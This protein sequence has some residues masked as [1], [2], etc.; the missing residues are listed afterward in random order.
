MSSQDALS[1][2]VVIPAHNEEEFLA[3]ALESVARQTVLPKKV[4]I[5]N[6]HSTD[7]TAKIIDEYSSKYP[8]FKGVN[9]HSSDEHLP[10]S[11]VV[12]AFNKGLSLLNKDYDFLVK[13]DADV[14]LPANYF[15]TVSEVFR[16]S[17]DIGIAGG[18]A[19]E[20]NP[21]GKWILKHPM[22][23][24][25]IRGAFKAYSNS[26]FQAMNGLRTAMGWDTVDELL[27]QYHGFRTAA[28]NSLKVKHQRPIGAAYNI[29][30][31]R[32]QGKAMFLM[33]YGIIITMIASLKMAL[34]NGK[35]RIIRDNLHGYRDARKNA[36]PYIV[37]PEEGKFIRKL[38]WKRILRKLI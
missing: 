28:V 16:S 27:A 34:K 6:D 22:D 24:D 25:H 35:L 18:Y 32:S 23:K 4:V 1:Y 17:P 19:Y 12:A 21:E 11:K 8:F 30:A 10:G 3:D 15:E 5:V 20:K 29:K 9:N 36:V 26:C 31:R 38:R 14:V 7:G 13:L 33:R 37:T 2:Y